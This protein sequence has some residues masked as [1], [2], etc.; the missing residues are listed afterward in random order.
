[1]IGLKT[2]ARSANVAIFSRKEV[3]PIRDIANR[4]RL[5]NRFKLNTAIVHFSQQVPRKSLNMISI[6]FWR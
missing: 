1:M 2:K 5:F 6:R 4:S 3:C